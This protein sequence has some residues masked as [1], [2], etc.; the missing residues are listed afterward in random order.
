MAMNRAVEAHLVVDASKFGKVR[1][2]RFAGISDF[3]SIIADRTMLPGM[4]IAGEE[5]HGRLKGNRGDPAG[6]GNPAGGQG[7]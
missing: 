4:P 6:G 2:A 7:R 1:P 3:A 5:P